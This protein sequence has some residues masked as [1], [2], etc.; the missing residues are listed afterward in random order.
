[1]NNFYVYCLFRPWNSEPCYIGKGRGK[2]VRAHDQQNQQHGNSHLA[3]IYK[4]ASTKTIPSV[5]LQEYLS[6]AKA[7]EYEMALIKAIGRTK[8]GGPLVNMTDG[9]EGS[10]GIIWSKAARLRAPNKKLGLKHTEESRERMSASRKGLKH[11]AESRAKIGAKSSLRSYEH[12]TRLKMRLSKKARWA[13]LSEVEREAK[14]N[15]LRIPK[16]EKWHTAIAE[17]RRNHNIARGIIHRLAKA[18]ASFERPSSHNH[19]KWPTL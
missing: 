8:H 5:V 14:M 9:G 19:V 3:R 4:R 13:G 10:S 17:G 1:M 11:T 16:T 15:H 18:Y 6:E 2:R 12:E 7:F